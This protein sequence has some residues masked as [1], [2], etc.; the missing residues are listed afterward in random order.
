MIRRSGVS[1]I[2]TSAIQSFAEYKLTRNSVTQIQI[3]GVDG[4]RDFIIINGEN[5][6]LSTPKTCNLSDNLIDSNG[7][8]AGSAPVANTGYHIYISNS[9]ASYAPSS[10]KL[11]ATSP[12]NEYLSSS[13]NGANWRWVGYLKTN[14]SNQL[15]DDYQVCGKGVDVFTA[16]LS[17]NKVRNSGTEQWYNDLLAMNPFALTDRTYYFVVAHMNA[18]FDIAGHYIQGRITIGTTPK[19]SKHIYCTSGNGTMPLTITYMDKS[20]SNKSVYLNFEYKYQG[21]TDTLTIESG[22]ASEGNRTKIEV[23]RITI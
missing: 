19:A 3:E 12:T 6:S 1:T 10:L 7:E 22:I 13:G 5:V 17:S 18:Y 9:K 16:A 20:N 11:S 21:G 2:Y 15:A 8:N 4:E 14:G 23:M